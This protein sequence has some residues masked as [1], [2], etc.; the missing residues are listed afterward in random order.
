MG[1]LKMHKSTDRGQWI[2][3]LCNSMLYEIMYITDKWKD[4]TCKR[5]LAKRNG[6]K[7]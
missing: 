2:T 4:V 7:K 5:C 6:R 1:K 3:M